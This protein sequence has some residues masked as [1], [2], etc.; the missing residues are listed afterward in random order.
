MQCAGSSRLYALSR[1]REEPRSGSRRLMVI[2]RAMNSVNLGQNA[3]LALLGDPGRSASQRPLRMSPGVPYLCARSAVPPI[4]AEH[5]DHAEPVTSLFD[6]ADSPAWHRRI[7]R[8]R[9]SQATS[10]W[11]RSCR[12]ATSLRGE[13]LAPGRFLLHPQ[14]KHLPITDV[15]AAGG[16]KDTETLLTCYQQAETQTLLA[17]MAEERKVHEDHIARTANA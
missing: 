12:P 3:E 9:V 10:F 17:V 13:R 8:R 5:A 14:R 15:A 2:R 6:H 7:V 4:H 11:W 16:W 1:H